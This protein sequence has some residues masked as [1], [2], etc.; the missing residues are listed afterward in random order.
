MGQILRL[1]FRELTRMNPKLTASLLQSVMPLLA[2]ILS[3]QDDRLA[4]L[5]LACVWAI[6]QLSDNIR[7]NP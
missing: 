6:V 5:R 1:V 7:L 3:S 4:S 2:Q